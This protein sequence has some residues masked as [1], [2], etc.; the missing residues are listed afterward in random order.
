[1]RQHQ[2]QEQ[3]LHRS[4]IR[5]KYKDDKLGQKQDKKFKHQVMPSNIAYHLRFQLNRVLAESQ[6]TELD[7]QKST[8]KLSL[9]PTLYIVLFRKELKMKITTRISMKCKTLISK[10]LQD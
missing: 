2:D 3:H 6:L 5:S 1:V 8:R 7:G 4:G 9:K 10:D